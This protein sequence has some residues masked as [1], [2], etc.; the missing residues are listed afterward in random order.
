MACRA[1][2]SSCQVVV[3][4]VVV[5]VLLP[6]FSFWKRDFRFRFFFLTKRKSYCFK[7][8][9]LFIDIVILCT[10]AN[11]ASAPAVS[12]DGTSIY[13]SR[14]EG[15]GTLSVN[16]PFVSGEEDAAALTL[17]GAAESP[18]ENEPEKM[19]EALS[20][21]AKCRD[22]LDELDSTITKQISAKQ[23]KPSRKN[24][25]EK[26]PSEIEWPAPFESRAAVDVIEAST[27]LG[28]AQTAK[29]IRV[30]CVTWNLA[31]KT[32]PEDLGP[33][34]PKNKFHVYAIATQECER[35]IAKSAFIVSKKK[36]EGGIAAALGESYEML[37]SHTLQAIHIAIFIR[38][39]LLPMV[40]EIN[41]AA[42]ATGIGNTLGNKGGVG[43][44]FVLGAT[45]FLFL[46]CH[47]AAGH[48]K[49]ADRN[50]DFHSIDVLLSV[51]NKRKRS[52]SKDARKSDGENAQSRRDVRAPASSLWS[53]RASAGP[54]M[55]A[56]PESRHP[57][58]SSER[59]VYS[60]DRVPETSERRCSNR[61][62]RIFWLGDLNYRIDGSKSIVENLIGKPFGAH[63]LL[64]ENDQLGSEKRLQ[65]AFRG[66]S[67]PPLNFF[68]TYKFDKGTLDYDTGKKQRVPSW[69]D[70]ILYR[71]VNADDINPRAYKSLPSF[72]TSD[73]IPVVGHFDVHFTCPDAPQEGDSHPR[74][75][76]VQS[77]ISKTQ[78]CSVM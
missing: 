68:P 56:V 32:P 31:G 73:H 78:V 25:S 34:L 2:S 23:R 26:S 24:V 74:L 66:Y 76:R 64:L 67:E 42:Q 4:V 75:H 55:S 20:Q 16:V 3:V 35:S 70:R 1:R 54:D 58:D 11:G 17:A 29:N 72:L 27:C 44:T 48:S 71:S 43:V 52:S 50:A 60:Y 40:T 22:E 65:N 45:S 53:G 28:A 51:G 14:C 7:S 33:L 49:V 18:L 59:T 37:R 19:S 41:S 6:S 12:D 46:S 15:A 77:G 47:L 36:W 9:S 38:K 39:E 5:V 8:I 62:D 21:Y 10:M 30:C 13:G 61:F 57:L 63:D 69:T